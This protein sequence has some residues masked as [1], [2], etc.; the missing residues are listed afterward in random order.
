MVSLS[1][2]AVAILSLQAACASTA[3]VPAIV[4]AS[5][6]VITSPPISPEVV[7]FQVCTTT[8]SNCIYM[9]TTCFEKFSFYSDCYPPCTTWDWTFRCNP[10]YSAVVAA[11]TTLQT[12]MSV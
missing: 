4:A 11:P 12:T 5:A 10:T 9:Y 6:A 2:I 3:D 8:A 7:D 1:S